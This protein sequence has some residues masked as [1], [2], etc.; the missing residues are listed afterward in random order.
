[1]KHHST[2][3]E[4]WR[5]LEHLAGSPDLKQFSEGEFATYEPDG[6][7]QMPSVTRRRFM[8]LMSAGMALA[9]M[10]LTG[11]R[12][13]PEEHLVP[14]T[15][16]P[17]DR[18]PGVPEQYATVAELSGVA[19]P[20]IA[21]SYDGRPIKLEGNPKHPWSQTV[22]GKRG[23]ADL[24]SQASILD[25]YD[26]D[27][28][29]MVL[30]DG[31]TP[32]SFE[33]FT[34]AFQP[35][36]DGLAATQGDGVAILM[37][38][39][40]GPSAGRL[41]SAIQQKY[42]KL[43]WC[44]YE[45]VGRENEIAGSRIACGQP[46]RQ[47]LHL[48][49]ANVVVLLDADPLGTHPAHTRYASDWASRRRNCDAS[50]S[51]V[52]CAETAL[53]IT[54]SVADNR[55]PTKPSR[56]SSLLAAIA[57]NFGIKVT[58]GDATLAADEKKFVD[59][60]VADLNANK[61]TSVVA[62]GSHLAPDIQALALALNST[63]GSMGK[64]LELR[65]E[66]MYPIT[67]DISDLTSKLKSGAI[68]TLLILDGNPVYDAPT[69]LNFAAAL[70]SATTIHLGLYANETTAVSQWHVPQAHYLEAWNDARAWDGLTSIA[71]PLIFPLYGGKTPSEILAWIAGES[72][73]DSSSIVHK[74][75][76][77]DPNAPMDDKMLN[78]RQILLAGFVPL[79]TAEM[80]PSF[81]GTITA[82]ASLT[83]WANNALEVRF[84]LD[85]S[86]YDGRFAPNGWMQE[87]PDPITKLV[88]DNA[89]LISKKDAD[90]LDIH[91]DG[92]TTDMVRITLNGRTLDIPAY[93]LP[94]QPIGVIGLPLGFGRSAA[95]HIG[96]DVGSN[97]YLLR[98]TDG[99]Y[100]GLG[101]TVEKTGDTYDLAM[102]QNH[103]LL[104]S[105]GFSGVE[106]RVG[107]EAHTSADIIRDGTLTEYQADPVMFQRKADGSLALQ[108]FD[109]P[110]QFTDPHAW[111]M[112]IDLTSC[113]G[114]HACVAA[115]QAE[116][117]I[118][119]VGKDQVQKNRQ[120]HW[121][122]IDRYFKGD[123]DAP[124]IVFQPVTCQQCENAPCEQVCP[125]GATMHDTE[126]LNVMVYNRC[127][128]TRY[129]SNN[130]PYKVRRFNYLDFHSQDPRHDKY[131]MPWLNIPDQ[132]QLDTIPEVKRMVFNPDVT[133]RMRGVMEKCSYCVQRIHNTQIVKRN[134]GEELAD[135]DILTACQQA[136]PTQAITF[137]DL[138][139][140]NSA[141]YQLHQSNR[142]YNLLGDLNTRPRNRYLAKV[143]NPSEA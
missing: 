10:T 37:Q 35:I 119:I 25:L 104:D 97:T 91:N 80:Y 141:V 50:M 7:L 44:V 86:R 120:M 79:A 133:V 118:P 128:G 82:P 45:P 61:G 58:G 109:P 127:I 140:Q 41:M 113:I 26:P 60:V 21:T 107:E 46:V 32:S 84:Q 100:T 111:G 134:A 132:Q 29:T 67:G 13:W 63:L 59:A 17:S 125:V 92:N 38:P 36:I 122:R 131:P 139:D 51:R 9:G 15:K 77:I 23:S 1:M 103:Y 129:C 112:A 73:T 65:S 117:N 57:S 12:R 106:E 87:I 108:L 75:F 136:C 90:E 94:G 66:P 130:C 124:E 62:V 30:K 40:S 99:M 126:G 142:S 3:R 18:S 39:L 93:I 105:I 20:L 28:S 101:A 115:C 95:G 49:V 121:I 14:Y 22:A 47:I 114:C 116:N 89:A 4:Y 2:K 8:Q 42:P 85:H 123:V 33:E 54:G 102:T 110:M 143:S 5:S 76:N 74:T 11:C 96:S 72:A 137:G 24:L 48:D 68:K 83:T 34:A 16:R 56:I 98:G 64:T 52:Y 31:T 81:N 88:W 43:Y 138:N 70:K 27:R 6:M 69:D 55:L 19:V 78:F 71:Q 135:G 53:T